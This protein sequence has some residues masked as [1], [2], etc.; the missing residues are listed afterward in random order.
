MHAAVTPMAGAATP[1]RAA[2]AAAPAVTAGAVGM[3]STNGGGGTT[4]LAGWREA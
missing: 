2:G 1:V 3:R 4:V